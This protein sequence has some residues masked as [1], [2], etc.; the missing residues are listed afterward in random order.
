LQLGFIFDLDGTL[1]DSTAHYRATW[2]ELIAEFGADHDPEQF[3]RRNT[4][5]N[6]RALFGDE[7]ADD[8]L[9]QHVARQANIGHA[10]MR[11]HGIEMH[12]GILELQ[13]GLKMRGVKLAVATSAE[14]SNA[15][16][17]LNA[18]GIREFFDAVVTDQDVD[19]GKPAPDVYR[20]AL[21]RLGVQTKHCAAIEDS[22]AGVRAAKGAGLRVIGV[23]TTHARIEL[24]QA[25]ADKIVLRAN[26]LNA[27][28][29]I[30]LI[31]SWRLETG[32]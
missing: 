24:E 27:D 16:W 5:D 23:V 11:A 7:I 17:T 19:N 10:K 15:E 8:E 1:V 21:R 20:E 18:L 13:N 3:L 14:R 32:D 25:G 31:E 2:A 6:F 26:E 22:A 29:V 9:E 30:R 28:V 4:R 12:D